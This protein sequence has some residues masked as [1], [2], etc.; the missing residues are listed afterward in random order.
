MNMRV[1]KF[2]EKVLSQ[3][4]RQ[5][6]QLK[7]LF[8]ET[9]K[10]ERHLERINGSVTEHKVEIAKVKTWGSLAILLVPMLLH[11]ILKGM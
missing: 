7:T 11:F 6:E 4:S 9:S 1:E 10:I 3:L 2:Q 8:K 5:E